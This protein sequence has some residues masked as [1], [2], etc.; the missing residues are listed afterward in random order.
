MK[1]FL[2]NLERYNYSSE[3]VEFLKPV[4]GSISN[5]QYKTAEKEFAGQTLKITEAIR[6]GSLNAGKADEIFTLLEILISDNFTTEE[7][8]SSFSS[9]F[10]DLLME[11][12]HLHHYEDGS[13]WGP[14]LDD[15]EKLAK[16]ILRE[17]S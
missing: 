4:A 15:I 16:S 12:M 10:S 1:D 3:I 7:K 5:G 14:K 9:P 13:G 8:K 6:N 2:N 17:T 11:G